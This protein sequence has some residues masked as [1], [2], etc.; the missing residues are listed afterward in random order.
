MADEL[1]LYPKPKN[2]DCYWLLTY[3][4][5]KYGVISWEEIPVKYLWLAKFKAWR[6]WN[7]ER[8][9]EKQFDTLV[10][11]RLTLGWRKKY[12]DSTWH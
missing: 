8:F 1:T 11:I 3:E 10:S 7:F 2:S 12:E 4:W 9:D 6:A 5:S